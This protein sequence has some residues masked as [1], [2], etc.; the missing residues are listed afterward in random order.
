MS[1]GSSRLMVLNMC[2][3]VVRNPAPRAQQRPRRFSRSSPYTGDCILSVKTF[4]NSGAPKTKECIPCKARHEREA[5]ENRKELAKMSGKELKE[6]KKVQY[7]VW[8]DNM[9]LGEKLAKSTSNGTLKPSVCPTLM[10]STQRSVRC[11]LTNRDGY[12]HLPNRYAVK[13]SSSRLAEPYQIVYS[14]KRRSS[15]SSIL[16]LILPSTLNPRL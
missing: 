1:V 4:D 3:T 5:K 14:L 15:P 9:N 6:R 2:K 11:A 10:T 8:Y 12:P 16:I 7:K 13:T